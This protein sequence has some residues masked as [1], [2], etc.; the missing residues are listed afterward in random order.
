MELIPKQ[1]EYLF[2]LA[3]YLGIILAV[4]VEHLTEILRERAFWWAAAVL[5][6]CWTALEIV[7]LRYRVWVYSDIQLCGLSFLTVPLEEYL[8][9][10]LI[11]LSTIGSWHLFQGDRIDLD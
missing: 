10:F 2:L 8:A 7:G 4:F 11:H 1:F 9:F 6:A 3:V 5:V